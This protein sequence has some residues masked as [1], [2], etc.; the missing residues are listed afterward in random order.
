[1]PV[2]FIDLYR[3]ATATV[4]ELEIRE[5]KRSDTTTDIFI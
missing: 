4:T 5:K 3:S 1:M 2:L